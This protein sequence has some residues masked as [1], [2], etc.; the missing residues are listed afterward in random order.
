M[1]V[2][3]RSLLVGLFAFFVQ[4]PGS[5]ILLLPVLLDTFLNPLGNQFGLFFGLPW[6]LCA[7][8]NSQSFVMA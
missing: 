7:L 8:G 4:L 5:G 2:G 3:W 1:R 6:S